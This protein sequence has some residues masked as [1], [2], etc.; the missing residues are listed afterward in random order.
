MRPSLNA[1]EFFN[2]LHGSDPTKLELNRFENEVKGLKR[3]QKC[4][5]LLQQ[6]VHLTLVIS[7]SVDEEIVPIA[8]AQSQQ[9][10]HSFSIEAKISLSNRLKSCYVLICPNCGQEVRSPRKRKI[11]CMNCNQENMLVPRCR[12]DVNLEDASG[13]TT[14]VIMDAEAEKLLSL[15]AAEIY[16]LV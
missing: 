11:R 3:I 14:G 2:L 8:N 1:D 10:G 9:D 5:S 12:F 16:D 7:V 4:S 13:S 15:T 6:E